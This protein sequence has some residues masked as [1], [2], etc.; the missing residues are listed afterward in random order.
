MAA[1]LLELSTCQEAAN[2]TLGKEETGS[3][4]VLASPGT[5]KEP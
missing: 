5:R 4:A 2:S 1:D 3:L